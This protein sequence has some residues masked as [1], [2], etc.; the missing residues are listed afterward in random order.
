MSVKSLR[1]PFLSD[2]NRIIRLGEVSALLDNQQKNFIA[3]TPWPEYEAKPKVSFAI[4][5]NGEHIFIKYDVEESEVLARYR[6][7][8]DPVY[9]DSCVE[10]FISFDDEK[11]YY[12]IEFNRLGTCLG[13][14]GTERENRTELPVDVL[15]TIKYERTLKQIKDTAEPLINW[16]LTV[17]V[18]IQVFCFHRLTSIQHQKA[19]MN[20][21][22]CGD[23][24]SQPHFL[25]WTNII[26]PEPDFHLPEFFGRVEF[27]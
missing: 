2:I 24:L 6:Q 12:N 5:H 21:Y 22:K 9:K 25:A 1:V 4:A 15:K 3:I 14:F 16:T 18:P 27:M 19:K 11:A 13:R 10:F 8:N 23:D 7:I 20:F 26:S 17:A